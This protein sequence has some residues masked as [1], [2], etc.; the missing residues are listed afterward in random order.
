MSSLRLAEDGSEDAEKEKGDDPYDAVGYGL[1]YLYRGIEATRR[2]KPQ[3]PEEWMQYIEPSHNR[4]SSIVS[5][6]CPY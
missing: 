3:I 6:I 4:P 2:K 1:M 5:G